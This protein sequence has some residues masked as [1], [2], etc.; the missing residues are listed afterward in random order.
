MEINK[1][2]I[3]MLKNSNSA[4]S[5]SH[6]NKSKNKNKNNNNNYCFN[7][8]NKGRHKCYSNNHARDDQSSAVLSMENQELIS[9]SPNRLPI[10]QQNDYDPEQVNKFTFRILFFLIAHFSSI[11][12]VIVWH[13][14]MEETKSFYSFKAM[15]SRLSDRNAKYVVYIVYSVIASFFVLMICISRLRIQFPLNYLMFFIYTVIMANFYG[16]ITLYH[17]TSVFIEFFSIILLTLFLLAMLCLCQR[18]LSMIDVPFFPY[19]YSYLSIM[20]FLLIFYMI[21]T[22]LFDSQANKP[23]LVNYFFLSNGETNFEFIINLFFSF[24]YIFYIIFDLQLILQEGLSDFNRDSL[25]CALNLLTKDVVQ[26]TFLCNSY[27]L[28][29]IK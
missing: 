22:Y 10:Q 4:C 24:F 1:C 18:K 25:T 7:N 23:L 12:I 9:L 13:S 28:N 8:L 11:I 3:C 21:K 16:Y 2:K 15:T 6:H 26:L 17:G 20:L 19:L 27:I 29:S 14:Y 5:L